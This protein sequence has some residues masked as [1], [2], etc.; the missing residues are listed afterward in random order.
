MAEVPLTYAGLSYL[1]RT[2]PIEL[3]EVSPGGISLNFVRFTTPSDIF[4]QQSQF[5]EFEASEMSMSTFMMLISRGDDHL[6]GLPVFPSRQFRHKDI[7]VN[8]DSGIDRPEDLVGR[9]VGVQEYQM[10]AALWVRAILQH[11]HGVAPRDIHWWSGGLATPGYVERLHH[12]LPSDVALESIPPDRT[13]EGM[14][15]SGELDALVSVK[16]PSELERGSTAI[17]RLFPE[18]R[19]V[20]RDYFLRTG[21]FRSCI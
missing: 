13:L 10:T 14:L 6:V 4:R 20:E 16:A 18:H 17:Q 12:D 8:A 19:Y 5:A 21:F 3:G 15:S 7:Y 11:E 9:N 2:V 1:D